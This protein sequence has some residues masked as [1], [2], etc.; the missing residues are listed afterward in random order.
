MAKKN[1]RQIIVKVSISQLNNQK[2]EIKSQLNYSCRLISPIV[3][4]LAGFLSRHCK[5]KSQSDESCST[6]LKSGACWEIWR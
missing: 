5:I 1:R 6:S 4:R 2:T 3:G